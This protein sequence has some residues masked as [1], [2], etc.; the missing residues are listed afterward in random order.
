[1]LFS[2]IRHRFARTTHRR[3]ARLH[4]QPLEDRTTPSVFTN[5]TVDD[6]RMQNPDAQFTTIMDAV[7][8]ASDGDRIL[9]YAGSYRESVV[10]PH[11]L[12][13]LSLVAARS[14]S[15]AGRPEILPPGEFATPAR[16]IVHVDGAERFTIRGFRIGGPLVTAVIGPDYGVLVDSNGSADV[17]ENDIV[18]IRDAVL[19]GRQE[20]VGIQFGRLTNANQ[21]TGRGRA[22]GNTVSDYQ[23]GGIVVIGEGSRADIL[24]NRVEGA[25]PTDVIAQNG[26]QV[27]DFARGNVVG[28][29]VSGNAYTGPDFAG[30]GIL[31]YNTRGVNVAANFAFENDYGIELDTAREVKV[32]L[33]RTFDNVLNGIDLFNSDDNEVVGNLATGNGQDGIALENAS[34]NRVTL[35]AAL[36]NGRDGIHLAEDTDHNRMMF[37]VAFGN[38]N[39]DLSDASSG[40][41]TAGTANLWRFNRFDTSDP[42]DLD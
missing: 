8:A 26:I 6:D 9:V 41:G 19:T 32:A 13:R 33:N 18:A 21:E 4:L 3:P 12:D 42:E 35:N 31:V 36:D 20:G 5:L 30:T 22:F 14:N 39:F 16:A 23:K 34:G 17:V 10:I 40:D 24:H 11:G 37:N 7:N 27:S 1:M 25:G 38:D 29:R 2:A 28:N 15:G